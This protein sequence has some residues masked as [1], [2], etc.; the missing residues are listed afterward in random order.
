MSISDSPNDLIEITEVQ[1]RAFGA[2]LRLPLAGNSGTGYL[3]G[4]QTKLM[5]LTKA[6][7]TNVCGLKVNVDFEFDVDFYSNFD[8]IVKF[9][10]EHD[11][12]KSMLILYWSSLDDSLLG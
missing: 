7:L 12:V 11:S 2:G 8:P 9:T 3:W 10:P 1:P 4:R 6:Y 5:E